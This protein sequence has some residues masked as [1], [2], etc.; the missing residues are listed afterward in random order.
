VVQVKVCAQL[1]A[2]ETMVQEEDAGVSVPVGAATV[3]VADLDTDPPGLVH[4]KMYVVVVVRVPVDP[5][6]FLLFPS[7]I[8]I[9]GVM[10]QLAAL[11]EVHVSV[12]RPP[13]ATD[14]GKAVSVAVGTA[15][16]ADGTLAR[17]N[18]NKI[19]KLTK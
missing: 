16:F 4:R 9:A 2:P 19:T 14:V 12:A 1:L 11:E 8:I 7:P 15:A 13:G 3:T 17:K 5:L 6:P 10:L 18:K